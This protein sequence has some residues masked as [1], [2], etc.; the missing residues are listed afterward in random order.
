MGGGSREAAMLTPPMSCYF[1]WAALYGPYAIEQHGHEEFRFQ[2]R[3]DGMLLVNG[4]EVKPVK[5]HLDGTSSS[6]VT[7]V[8]SITFSQKEAAMLQLL[9]AD[10]KRQFQEMA[11][12]RGMVMTGGVFHF[13]ELLFSDQS[14]IFRSVRGGKEIDTSVGRCSR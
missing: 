14:V 8:G 12:G 11:I 5:V 10:Q 6:A 2:L 3:E 9:P 1:D 13:I 4:H 7:D